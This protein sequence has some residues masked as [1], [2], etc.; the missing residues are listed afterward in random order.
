MGLQPL[1]L[2]VDQPP[3][4]DFQCVTS[5]FVN[6]QSNDLGS[7]IFQSRLLGTDRHGDQ[8]RTAAI[9]G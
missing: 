8:C 6:V 4:H 9:N 5:D 7:G 2:A 1:K 3:D